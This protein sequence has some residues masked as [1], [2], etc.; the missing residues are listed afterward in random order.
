MP[1]E[2]TVEKY[3]SEE[4][5]YELTEPLLILNAGPNPRLFDVDLTEPVDIDQGEVRTMNKPLTPE[6]LK[7]LDKV[8]YE[9]GFISS[10]PLDVDELAEKMPNGIHLELQ[11]E[12]G[13]YY[14]YVLR[15]DTTDR[16]VVYG[17]RKEAASAVRTIMEKTDL[18]F[19]TAEMD[20]KP[21]PVNQNRDNRLEGYTKE[22]R[23]ELTGNLRGLLESEFVERVRQVETMADIPKAM[24][25][26][27]NI[28]SQ[29]IFEA[30]GSSYTST[31]PNWRFCKD[32]INPLVRYLEEQINRRTKAAETDEPIE[33][34]AELADD[35]NVVRKLIV[36]QSE[37]LAGEQ[38]EPHHRSVLIPIE[39]LQGA[40][41]H[42][43]TSLFITSTEVVIHH[44]E[45]GIFRY[46]LP[47]KNEYGEIAFKGG[48]A[49]VIAKVALNLPTYDEL[50]LS[51][52]DVM[53]FGDDRK[54][55]T[56][57]RLKLH[58]GVDL[59]DIEY[60]PER[61]VAGYGKYLGDRDQAINEVLMTKD[62]LIIS[63]N[64]LASYCQQS[65]EVTAVPVKGLF[66]P[67]VHDV[68]GRYFA[69]NA[70]V[71]DAYLVHDARFPTTRAIARMYRSMIE[72]K[73]D[74]VTLPKGAVKTD[75]G[76]QWLIMARKFMDVSD[77]KKREQLLQG[78]LTMAYLTHSRYFE[79]MGNKDNVQ[80]FIAKVK[81]MADG[82]KDFDMDSGKLD[83]RGT[84]NWFS[85][86]LS[87][88]IVHEFGNFLGYDEAASIKR[89]MT[90]D[91]L[92]PTQLTLPRPDL[93]VE[94][95][96]EETRGLVREEVERKRTERY[97]ILIE[98]FSEPNAE[99]AEAASYIQGWLEQNIP[100]RADYQR[101]QMFFIPKENAQQFYQAVRR[102]NFALPNMVS[103]YDAVSNVT[104]LVEGSYDEGL[105]TRVLF[106]ELFHSTVRNT[107]GVGGFLEEGLVLANWRNFV[108]DHGGRP[109]S[110]NTIS[111][112]AGEVVE[113][114]ISRVGEIEG[115]D[116]FFADLM[117]ARLGDNSS[118]S[119]VEW[120]VDR[121]LGKGTFER[122][123]SLEPDETGVRSAYREVGLS[124]E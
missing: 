57:E 25:D 120:L 77:E 20:E 89:K 70:F 16:Y 24:R 109:T 44:E 67:H 30:A 60:I 38:T 107:E 15:H 34:I 55:I 50:P 35:Y 102:Q 83:D 87:R 106:E 49:R 65:T 43:D 1:N 79:A 122:L 8:T 75:I 124:L 63:H 22:E 101:C 73:V 85:E 31:D 9:P 27:L 53:I 14:V 7:A 98:S 74:T 37:T 28:V 62:G 90:V 103:Q 36:G 88:Q 114:L 97:R 66:G 76:I 91:D 33:F 46:P 113:E 52:V 54:A 3:Y 86:K 4:V 11:K 112:Y 111:E 118:S 80:E 48:L 56:T 47:E 10:E 94:P 39:K 29:T 45:K 21:V 42:D 51:D 68:G 17:T 18:T 93:Y 96:I 26:G 121:V 99:T 5:P 40:Q 116:A 108:S 69:E 41:N 123:Q 71:D 72:G 84:L 82:G 12:M 6:L 13:P 78:M 115:I 19:V 2:N 95:E 104:F 32:H 92:L 23:A 58:Y 61:G 117:R 81:E 119:K 59:K 64:A 100:I 110:I 105:G